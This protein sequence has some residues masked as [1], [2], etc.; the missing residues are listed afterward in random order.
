MKG[1][2]KAASLRT[3]NHSRGGAVIPMPGRFRCSLAVEACDSATT[4]P[5]AV[6]HRRYPG[7]ETAARSGM[8]G[9]PH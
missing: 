3:G 1:T 6:F 7:F 5:R 9:W 8:S 4:D 2:Y